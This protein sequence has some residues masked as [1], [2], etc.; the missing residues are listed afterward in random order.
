MLQNIIEIVNEKVTINCDPSKLLYTTA[1]SDYIL[2]KTGQRRR[3]QTKIAPRGTEQYLK[4]VRCIFFWTV[5]NS[6]EIYKNTV[7]ITMN[8]YDA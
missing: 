6:V 8:N 5:N 4:I 2:W 1:I 7:M 3:G